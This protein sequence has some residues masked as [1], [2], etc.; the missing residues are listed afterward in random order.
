MP[1]THILKPAGSAGFENLPVIEWLCLELGRAAGF[2]VPAAAL[3]DMPDGMPPALLVE[4]FDVRRSAQDQRLLALE[5][6]C[7]LLELP[8]AAKY[9]STIERCAKTLRAVSTAPDAD[10][11]LLLRRAVF[12]WLIG[13]GD[14]HL[15][16]LAVLRAAEPGS[17]E[18]ASVRLAPLFDAVSTRVFPRLAGDRM[19]LKLNGRD[20]GLGVHDFVA[21]GKTMGIPAG[22]TKET[23]RELAERLGASALALPASARAAEP[24]L[25]A[26]RSIIEARNPALLGVSAGS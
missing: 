1:F 22:A 12:A 26:L 23:C 18:F 17:R 3:I 11:A 6:F 24:M 4:R 8:A 25:D 13:D 15:K 16:N 10:L 21:A 19:A 14:M 7:S 9:D 5:D 20:D 2:D